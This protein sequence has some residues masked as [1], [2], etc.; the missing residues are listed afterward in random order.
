MR[1]PLETLMYIMEEDAG[2]SRQ[3]KC[4]IVKDKKLSPFIIKTLSD[5]LGLGLKRET[6]EALNRGVIDKLKKV[7]NSLDIVKEEE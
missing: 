5:G 4:Q 1:N 7:I 3:R 2:Y 6:M